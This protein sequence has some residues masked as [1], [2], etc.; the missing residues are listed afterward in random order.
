M[1]ADVSSASKSA[2]SGGFL[3]AAGL[4]AVAT[5]L[6]KL[7]GLIRDWMIFNAY[8]A[9]L[10]TDAYFAAFQIPSF[11][12]ILLGGLGGPFHT[13]T[14]SVLTHLLTTRQSAEPAAGEQAEVLARRIA[15]TLL[16]LTGLVFAL[17]S[18]LL[19][20][21]AEPLMAL[22]LGNTADPQLLER[23]AEMLRVMSPVFLLGGLMGIF[24]GVLNVYQVFLWPSLSPA[25]QSLCMIAGLLLWGGDSTGM[26]LAWTT[27]GGAIAQL[28][29]QLPDY[30]RRGYGL[31]P[32]LSA[33]KLPEL[34]RIG[35]MLFPATVGTTIGQAT[36]YVD[37]FF[38][39]M[40]PVGAWSA[41]VLSNRL[42]QFPL[43]VLQTAL[44]VPIFPRFTR[45]AAAGDHHALGEDFRRGVSGL[46]L[47]S[48]PM[49][50]ILLLETER[51]VRLTFQHGAFNPAAT[52]VVT[53]AIVFQAFQIVPY[54][55]RDSLTRVFYAFQD[56]RT[57]LLVGLVAIGLKALLNWWWVVETPGF[58]VGG[59]TLSITVITAVNM[60]FL[61]VLSRRYTH[62]L[63]FKS[64]LV[65]L[66]KLLMAGGAMYLAVYA[67]EVPL[68]H[69]L[70]ET[71][72]WLRD[73][74]LLL[75]S[76]V[77]GLG[78]YAL[79][80]WILRLPEVSWL[81]ERLLQRFQKKA[82]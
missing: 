41:V 81:Q 61:A 16:T 46:W 30:L 21:M 53:D 58:G 38:A 50:V 44:L 62:T 80:V 49:L 2:V 39:A 59:I 35:E 7:L 57:P 33:W 34:R 65:T 13:A 15:A 5:L 60:V 82:S 25:A 28:L 22:I 51:I 72:P 36:V 69:L 17:L 12:L 29:V 77:C 67:M 40:L 11:A 78:V 37:M 14:V 47:I 1:A 10:V 6:S 63:H 71:S 42:I 79:A 54:F 55:A 73:G 26:L 19:G 74:V 45:H 4:I 23:S 64:L 56:T 31:R 68:L 66:F 48:I 27:L 43:G 75:A 76:S 3:Q 18:L 8:G 9:S 32:S 70:G 52:R 20:L 24:F